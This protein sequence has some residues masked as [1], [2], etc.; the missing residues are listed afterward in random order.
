[1]AA[2]A[3]TRSGSGMVTPCHRKVYPKAGCRFPDLVS[4]R[5]LRQG[6][7]GLEELGKPVLIPRADEELRVD[8]PAGID[9]FRH[10]RLP[11]RC[12]EVFPAARSQIRDPYGRVEQDAAGYLWMLD[13]GLAPAL[14]LLEFHLDYP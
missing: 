13:A 5:N 9:L 1:M 2:C 8:H 6:T 10:Q 12:L 3:I 14:Q 11:H 4:E 7:Q